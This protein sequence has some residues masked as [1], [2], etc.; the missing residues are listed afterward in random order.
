MPPP[1]T[2]VIHARPTH[3]R[4][5]DLT[6]KLPCCVSPCSRGAVADSARP[7]ETSPMSVSLGGRL[8]RRA[9]ELLCLAQDAIVAVTNMATVDIVG[10]LVL[11]CD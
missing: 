2:V 6:P 8:L 11:A 9:V 7:D 4:A 5:T 1:T 10:P 3:E